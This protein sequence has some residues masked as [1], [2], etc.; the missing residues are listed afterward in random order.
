MT[1]PPLNNSIL[2]PCINRVAFCQGNRYCKR[3]YNV[4]NCY[5]QKSGQVPPD[6]C[7]NVLNPAYHDGPNHIPAKNNPYNCNQNIDGPFQLCIFFGGG[8]SKHK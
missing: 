1:V 8:N 6:S 2:R 3:V 4:Q 5:S 7:V